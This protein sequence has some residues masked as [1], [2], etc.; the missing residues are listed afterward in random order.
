MGD[1]RVEAPFRVVID[2]DRRL[3][4]VAVRELAGMLEAL[5]G[6]VAWA[7]GD[8]LHRPLHSGAGRQEGA[9]EDAAR[10]RLVSLASGSIDAAVLPAAPKPLPEGGFDH[11]AETLSEQSFG[12]LLTVAGGAVEGHVDLARAL[13]DFTERFASQPGAS[14]RL[15]DRR[16][17]DG[18]SVI[19][20]AKRRED[21]RHRIAV[22][23]AAPIPKREVTGRIYQVNV[24]TDTAL[25]RTPQGD[26]V[27]IEFGRELME[28]MKRLLGDRA[29][30]RGEVTYDPRTQRAKSVRIREIM[31]GDQLGLDFG[32]VD[33]WGDR[34]VL[35]L[36]AEAGGHPVADP[37]ELEVHGASKGEWDALYE[38]LGNGRA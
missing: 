12:L 20:D 11:E 10:I 6:L 32:G 24:E 5:A 16:P 35:E 19:V 26:R 38:V 23:T 27:D 29:S 25:V 30:L 18:R 22:A 14:L 1:I 21:L 3:E 36:I 33:F 37:S 34:P 9:I 15:E 7:S 2:G 13:V 31:T 28:D 4:D 8:I 17:A